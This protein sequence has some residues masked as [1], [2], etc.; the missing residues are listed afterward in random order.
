[1]GPRKML[2]GCRL[3]KEGLFPTGHPGSTGSVSNMA[4]PFELTLVHLKVRLLV[5]HYG[6]PS[7]LPSEPLE[8]VLLWN[9]L[10]KDP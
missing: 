1:M 6:D 10:L 7:A 3:E 2:E 4:H 5:P 8:A 9:T